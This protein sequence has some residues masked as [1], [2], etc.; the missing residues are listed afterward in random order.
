MHFHLHVPI[1]WLIVLFMALTVALA[2]LATEVTGTGWLRNAGAPIAP[3]TLPVHG[4]GP[5]TPTM[6]G[7]LPVLA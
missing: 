5:A 6:S 7:D 2:L 3:V 4:A 1:T